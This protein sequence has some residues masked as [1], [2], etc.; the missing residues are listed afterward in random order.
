[1]IVHL[2]IMQLKPATQTQLHFSDRVVR[3]SPVYRVRRHKASSD[4]IKR[5]KKERERER[6][7]GEERKIKIAHHHPYKYRI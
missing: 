1:M 7:R 3:I 5:R 4:L 6:M 2:I